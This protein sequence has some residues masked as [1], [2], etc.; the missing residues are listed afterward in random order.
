VTVTDIPADLQAT[1]ADFLATHEPATMSERDFLAARFDAGLAWV[2]FPVGMGGRDAPRSHQS[3]I[4]DALAAAGARRSDIIRNPIGLGMAA[5]TLRYHGTPAQ[6]SRLLRPL[7][8]GEEVWCQL[9]SEPGAGS[10]LASLSTH[11]AADGDEW[12]INGQKV[13]TSGAHRARWALLLARTDPARPKHQG[14]TYFLLDMQTPG[15]QV[16]P[17]RQATGQAEFNEVFLTDVRIS[18]DMRLGGVGEGWAVARTTLLNERSEIGARTPREAGNIGRLA[19]LW[20]NRPDLRTPEIY[21]EVL[22]A[23]AHTEISRIT[24]ERTCQKTAAGQPGFEGSGAKVMYAANNQHITRLTVQINPADALLYDSWD[25]DGSSSDPQDPSRP[26]T[27]HY[28]RARANS[29]E[30]GTTEILLGQIADRV[31]DLP[32]ESRLDPSTPWQELSR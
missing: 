28:L 3:S 23:W 20:R 19:A 22:D 25:V 14:L 15:V 16:R 2:H 24:N 29:I 11:A 21:G 6:H 7:W 31:L 12:I 4:E 32:R 30:G 18:N 8:T 1:L 17:L 27:F 9:F 10:D 26:D 5:P 13:W